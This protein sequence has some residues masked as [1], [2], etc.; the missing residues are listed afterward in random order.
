[1]GEEGGLE[2]SVGGL[3]EKTL[4]SGGWRRILQSQLKLCE[5]MTFIGWISH[6]QL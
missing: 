3:Q 5:R 2:V 6:G 4:S 1:M